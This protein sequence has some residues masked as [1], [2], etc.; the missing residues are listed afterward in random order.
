MNCRFRQT[1]DIGQTLHDVGTKS[2][3]KLL[4]FTCFCPIIFFMLASI[5]ID[6]HSLFLQYEEQPGYLLIPAK[7]L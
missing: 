2:P 7:L 4:V 6:F 1:I 5:F 3:Y